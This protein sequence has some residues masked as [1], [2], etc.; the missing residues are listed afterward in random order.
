MKKL[1]SCFLV[2][3]LT[4]STAFA[5]LPPPSLKGLTSG[6][7]TTFNF[8]VPFSQATNIAG[9]TSLIETGN[10]NLL[11]DGSMEDTVNYNTFWIASSLLSDAGPTQDK[12][13][14]GN[15]SYGFAGI[16]SGTSYV[17][18]K[19][20]NI[21]QGLMGQNCY[22]E[23]TYLYNDDGT[24]TYKTGDYTFL[25][26][27]GSGNVLSSEVSLIVN[28]S[29]DVIP[30][31]ASVNYPCGTGNNRLRVKAATAS[32]QNFIYF[33][34][35]YLGSPKNVGTVQ[36]AYLVGGA[37]VTGCSSNW[38]TSSTSLAVFAAQT[39]CSY[40]TF[41]AASAPATNVPGIK[42]S[43]LPPGDYAIQ[44]EGYVGNNTAAKEGYFQFSDGTTTARETSGFA[45]SAGGS[46]A[47]TINQSFNYP[48]AQSSVTWQLKAKTDSGGTAVVYGTTATSGTFKLWY[49]P[50]AAQQA[51][52]PDQ[53]P[54]SWNGY[55]TQGGATAWARTNTAYGDFTAT[56]TAAIVETANRNFG[57]VTTAASN[58]PG[59]IVSF[60]KAGYYN[61]CAFPVAYQSS[62]VGA[63]RLWDGTT[64]IAE[65]VTATTT[66]TT[67]PLCGIYNATSTSAKTLSIQARSPAGTANI[68]TPANTSSASIYWSIV[69]LDQG[70]AVPYLQGNVTSNTS[71]Q[72]RIE[73]VRVT[74]TCTSSPC[75]I[76][77]QSGSWLSSVTRASTGTYALVINSGIFSAAPTCT[78]NLNGATFT[79]ANV[80]GVSATSVTFTTNNAAGTL[81]DGSFNII[82]MG[83]K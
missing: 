5:G 35:A 71:G 57:T 29:T 28:S 81:T 46:E 51:A 41:G 17:S 6:S 60:P 34:N 76:A 68:D 62:N 1:I 4:F 27:D 33:D 67:L 58:L 82:C 21:P 11:P 56:G 54:A 40:A 24:G 42:F 52:K 14:F 9:T 48:T 73:R 12:I 44:Y 83:S 70:M 50:T 31:V 22:A 10:M 13:L 65:N 75:T 8:T 23:I 53:T 74:S 15:W 63:F 7:Y 45:S 77:S 2:L 61:V 66:R 25:V 38:S 16:G 39:G 20:V 37:V 3:F 26:D 32:N 47:S 79:C 30:H 72:E 43:S 69:A 36:Q 19:T 78:C 64:V 55:H 49:F 18:S 59:I 80:I